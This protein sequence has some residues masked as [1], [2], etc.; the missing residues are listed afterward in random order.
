MNAN[1]ILTGA[2]IAPFRRAGLVFL[3]GFYD[4]ARAAVAIH[5][6][7]PVVS[8][9]VGR[10]LQVHI[11][12][13]SGQVVASG[14]GNDAHYTVTGESVNLASRLTDAAGPGG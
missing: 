9:Q 10:P 4:A 3:P 2:R 13:A 8:K 5:E 14:I 7:M 11:G 12:I 1:R 6:V